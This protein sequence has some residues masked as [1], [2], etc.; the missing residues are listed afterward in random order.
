[1][2]IYHVLGPRLMTRS[3]APQGEMFVTSN[4]AK[5]GFPVNFRVRVMSGSNR[6]LEMIVEKFRLY[7]MFMGVNPPV[8]DRSKWDKKIIGNY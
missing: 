3:G 2:F 6:F 8:G 5:S 1:M 7:F 4:D